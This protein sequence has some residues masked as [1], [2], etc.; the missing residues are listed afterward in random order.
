MHRLE[1]ALGELDMAAIE[2][3]GTLIGGSWQCCYCFDDVALDDRAD[4]LENCLHRCGENEQKSYPRTVDTPP[5]ART[6]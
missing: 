2:Y 1:Y 5:K 6:T 4:V 3:E